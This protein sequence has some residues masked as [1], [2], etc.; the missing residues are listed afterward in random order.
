MP[1]TLNPTRAARSLLAYAAAVCCCFCCCCCCLLLLLAAAAAAAACLQV[2]CT[3]F[4]SDVNVT[5]PAPGSTIRLCKS[6][7]SDTREF[8]KVAYEVGT[9]TG[10]PIPETQ[11]VRDAGGHARFLVVAQSAQI[12]EGGVEPLSTH[13]LFSPDSPR[14]CTVLGECTLSRSVR[15]HAVRCASWPDRRAVGLWCRRLLCAG[16]CKSLTL[17]CLTRRPAATYFAPAWSPTPTGA[18]NRLPTNGFVLSA[19]LPAA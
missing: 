4:Y 10:K 12:Q 19:V 9:G 1:C 7:W 15:T 3:L 17:P 2:A 18:L 8:N 13:V 16:C 5:Q 14:C 11:E 6:S